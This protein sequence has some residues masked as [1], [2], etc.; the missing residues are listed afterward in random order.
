VA[1]R[2]WVGGSGT[3][4]TTNTANWSTTSG[5][6]GG[7]SVPTSSL[8]PVFFDQAGTYTVTMTGA[9]SCQTITVSAG[10]VTFATGTTPTL[11]L[12]GGL[13]LIAGTV[14]NST[15]TITINGPIASTLTTNGVVIGGSINYNRAGNTC[16]LAGALTLGATRTFTLTAGTLNLA[17]YT[18][19]TGAFNSS[20]SNTRVIAFGTGNIT[21]NGAGGTLW[22]TNTITG[23]T[24]TGNQVVNVSNS[25]A[26]A[27][28]VSSGSLT[29]ANSINFN[30]TTG[31]YSLTHTA[32]TKRN[33]NFT[34]FAGTV[35]N[36][37]QTIYGDLTLASGATYTAGT[38]TWTFA[39]TAILASRT[40]TTNGRT[41]DWP[42]T[43]NATGVGAKLVLQDALTMGSTRLF[44]H[45]NGVLNLNGKTLTVGSSYT[46]GIGTKDLTFNG[47]TLICS[48]NTPAAFSNAAPTGFTTT[49]GTGTGTI[50]MT[51]S[52]SKSF[53]GGGSTF[54]C[55]LNQ[56]GAGTL[57]I[58]G[59][60]TFNNITNTV[61]PATVAFTTGT[62]NTFNNFSLSGTAGN[63]ITLDGASGTISKASGTVSVDY[64]S[65]SNS[66]ATGGAS[67]YAG[68]NSTN[69]GGNTGWI[70]TA[71]PTPGGNTGAFFSIL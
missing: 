65:I 56:G 31:T 47:G 11:A 53:A 49:A 19:T 62:T 44:T 66:N 30:F 22:D 3:W 26:V 58:E 4:N 52:A 10:T 27:T 39:T 29:E 68:A 23:L 67:W 1:N 2:Y 55:T 6:A 59:G 42:L 41:V 60:N 33:L 54:N 24:T 17:S 14:W 64:L 57:N 5:G 21:V 28:T 71:P 20:F 15:G 36:S 37:T 35:S 9:L 16:T 8:D 61:Q 50:S 70:F 43:V 45:S 48:A 63:L 34:G 7:A 12:N 13:N 18:L 25:G 32:G 51:G 40:I 38:S 69:G 46:T